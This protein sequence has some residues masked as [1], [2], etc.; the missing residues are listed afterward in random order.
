MFELWR[1]RRQ[2]VKSNKLYRTELEKARKEKKSPDEIESLKY[3]LEAD[4][5]FIEEEIN[6]LVTEHLIEKARKLFLSTSAEGKRGNLTGLFYLTPNGIA[7][8]RS[9]IREETAARR[10][11]FLEWASP[12]V[13]IIGAITG[14][15]AVIFAMT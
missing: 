14:L 10:K 6:R 1:K 12:I 13:G 7:I 3:G 15:L 8:I 11:A 5:E 4:I 2:L 9:R